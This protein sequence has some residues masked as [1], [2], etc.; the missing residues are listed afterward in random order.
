[1]SRKDLK[2]DEVKKLA[3]LRDLIEERAQ[4][5]ETE[6]EGLRVILAF[7]NDLLLEKSF[8]R[9]EIPKMVSPELAESIKDAEA[10]EA[11]TTPS[12]AIQLKTVTGELLA[13]LYS[14]ED[15]MR[16][17]LAEDKEFDVNTP[18]FMAFLVQRILVK[19]QERDQEAVNL[20]EIPSEKALS[21]S[22]RRDGDIIREI[23]IQ[24]VNP[25]RGQELRSAIR[26]TL[27]KMYEKTGGT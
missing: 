10:V 25:Q 13:D 15:F 23:T 8:K 24:N 27:E 17:V 12:R 11:P 4:K 14:G 6:L 7:V 9:V 1:M 3:E 19:M 22:I 5:L 18:P 26:W 21:F 20:G 2:D 16:V